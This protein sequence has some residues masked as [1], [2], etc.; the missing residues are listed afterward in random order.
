MCRT[1]PGLIFTSSSLPTSTKSTLVGLTPIFGR[2]KKIKGSKKKKR[3]RKK[4]RRCNWNHQQL[5]LSSPGTPLSS[6]GN[7]LCL[8]P[9]PAPQR[10]TPRIRKAESWRHL[11]ACLAITALGSLWKGPSSSTAAGYRATGRPVPG[12]SKYTQPTAKI[13]TKLVTIISEKKKKQKKQWF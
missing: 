7:V 13:V 11:A 12:F 10:L 4:C 2:E 6:K 9:L 8:H 5:L 1:W 3:E